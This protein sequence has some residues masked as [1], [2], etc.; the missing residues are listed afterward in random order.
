MISAIG[1]KEVWVVR[2]WG[3]ATTVLN[4]VVR[5]SLIEKVATGQR[6]EG[7]SHVNTHSKAF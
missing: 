3:W 1:E 2:E 6:L 4:M 7:V 5:V